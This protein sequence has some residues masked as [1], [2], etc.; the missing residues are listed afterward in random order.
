MTI[1]T[2]V[3]SIHPSVHPSR[4]SSGLRVAFKSLHF[5][6]VFRCPNIHPVQRPS[7]ER[8]NGWIED[9]RQAS[10]SKATGTIIITFLVPWTDLLTPPVMG[11]V[12]QVEAL[13]SKSAR[14][15]CGQLIYI[16]HQED[17]QMQR[18]GLFPG[19]WSEDIHKTA[20]G[21]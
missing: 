3:P 14:N 17:N 1:Y 4:S 11:N 10:S 8:K 19:L 21:E 5:Q 6:S 16:Q 9:D 20:F 13:N 2:L 12:S 18:G 15:D 7:N